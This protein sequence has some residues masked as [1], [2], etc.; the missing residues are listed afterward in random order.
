MKAIEMVMEI[1][2]LEGRAPRWTRFPA[3]ERCDA[4]S[5]ATWEHPTNETLT[6]LVEIINSE[7]ANCPHVDIRICK[8]TLRTI[9]VFTELDEAPD[10]ARVAI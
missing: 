10:D 3:S 2:L 7:G 9:T 6:G 1:E 8:T 4:M 5:T